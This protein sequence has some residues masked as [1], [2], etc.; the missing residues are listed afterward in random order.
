MPGEDR[1]ISLLLVDDEDEF[2]VSTRRILER[3]GFAVAE[4]A[5]G[6][7]ALASVEGQRPD[8]VILDLKMPGL[9]GIETLRRIRE[10]DPDLPAIILTGHGSFHDAFAGAQLSIVDFLSKPVDVDRLA[11]AIRSL[12][13]GKGPVEPLREPDIGQLMVS[14]ATYPTVRVDLSLGAVLEVV[15][16]EELTALE[17]EDGWPAR[18]WVVVCDLDD[19]FLGMVSFTDLLRLVIPRFLSEQRLTTFFTGMFVA[20]SMVLDQRALAEALRPCVTVDKEAPLMMAVH[21]MVRNRLD[22][23]P[24]TDGPELAGILE[25]RAVVREMARIATTGS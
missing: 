23:L 7:Q 8:L 18:R 1:V 17:G 9:D 12:L 16:R 22:C 3:R 20:Q 21:L 13:L 2:R 10:R 25:D 19:A 5:S 24:V 6:E 14:P 15:G 4:A 11:S